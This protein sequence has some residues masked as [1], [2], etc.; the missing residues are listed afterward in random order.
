MFLRREGE[1]ARCCSWVM[2]GSEG[3]PRMSRWSTTPAGGWG[4]R[5]FAEGVTGLS[6]LHPLIDDQLSEDTNLG[7]VIVGR[8]KPTAARGCKP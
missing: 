1:D 3:P 5:G 7:R 4:R 8:S 6:G 2:A